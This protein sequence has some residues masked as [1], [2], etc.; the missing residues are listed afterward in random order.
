M[1]HQLE[2]CKQEGQRFAKVLLNAGYSRNQVA[3]LIRR[4]WTGDGEYGSSRDVVDGA[5]AR[6][7]ASGYRM[8]PGWQ[9]CLIGAFDELD[10]QRPLKTQRVGQ[11]LKDEDR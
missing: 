7:A 4:V 10:A 2:L 5:S 11:A 8:M 1:D 3:E 9:A 6:Q